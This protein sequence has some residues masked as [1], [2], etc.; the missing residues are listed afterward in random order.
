MK[1]DFTTFETTLKKL[2]KAITR[3]QA[4]PS[5]KEIR[6]AVILR[7]EYTYA[8]PY[9]FIKRRLELEA[10]E[11]DQ[12][13]SRKLLQ[14]AAERRIIDDSQRWITY[15]EN[16]DLASHVYN[17][18]VSEKVY[19]LALEFYDDALILLTRLINYSR[20]IL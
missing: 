6:D 13:S 14:K 19:K 8:L 2:K 7:F 11:V 5:D 4:E 10:I 9:K 16:H 15:Q 3:S 18:E 17:E 20:G 1:L 12:L